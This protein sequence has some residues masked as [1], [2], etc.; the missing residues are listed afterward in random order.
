MS[1]KLIKF[2][3]IKYN[4]YSLFLFHLRSMKDFKTYSSS[5]NSKQDKNIKT[6]NFVD[7]KN[8]NVS[9]KINRI[10][11]ESEFTAR[12]KLYLISKWYELEL[13][14]IFLLIK[15][16]KILNLELKIKYK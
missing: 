1:Y 7:S 11:S 16:Q 4:K 13:I 5:Q 3:N 6:V 2:L 10:E 14:G 12:S 15:T 8:E 9:K